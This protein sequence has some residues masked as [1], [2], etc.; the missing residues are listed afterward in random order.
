MPKN[1]HE[2]S[3][4]LCGVT[5]WAIRRRV[6]MFPTTYYSEGV[7][8]NKIWRKKRKNWNTSVCQCTYTWKKMK[9]GWNSRR[10]KKK[11]NSQVLRVGS[12]IYKYTPKKEKGEDKRRRKSRGCREY[13]NISR[14]PYFSVNSIGNGYNRLTN[15]TWSNKWEEWVSVGYF[16]LISNASSDRCTHE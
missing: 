5:S 4:V 2:S 10:K 3:L 9:G 16:I 6:V 13:K 11:Q 15:P 12:L 14:A 1:R 8:Q 7:L